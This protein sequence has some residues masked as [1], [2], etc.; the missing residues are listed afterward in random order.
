M[1]VGNSQS[2]VQ[3][4]VENTPFIKPKKNRLLT[5]FQ[6]LLFLLMAGAITFLGY[7]NYQLRKQISQIQ[8]LPKDSTSACRLIE[9]YRNGGF[10]GYCDHLIVYTDGSASIFDDCKNEEKDFQ[11]KPET[12]NQLTSLS[13]QFSSFF[14]ENEDI[15]QKSGQAEQKDIVIIPEDSPDSLYTKL[16]FYGQGSTKVKKEQE[17]AIEQLI[18]SILDQRD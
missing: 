16:I 2:Q 17:D 10:V 1:E 15:N 13:Q 18:Y 9:Y 4:Q 14:S 5:I 7:Q 6:I 12:L 8:I 3:S 11:V